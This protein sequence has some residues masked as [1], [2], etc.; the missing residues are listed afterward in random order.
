MS[1]T[2][3]QLAKLSNVSPRTLRFYD[4][5]GLLKPAYYGDNNYRYYEEEQL[6]I[7]QQILFSVS[8]V[9]L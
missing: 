6:L 4:E 2:V 9:F 8:L 5:I 7:L 1:Y 3:K